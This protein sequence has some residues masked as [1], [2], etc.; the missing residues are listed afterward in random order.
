[1]YPADGAVETNPVEFRAEIGINS[2]KQYKSHY[3]DRVLCVELTEGS[4]WNKC[5]PM[6]NPSIIFDKLPIGNYTARAFITDVNGGV[7]WYHQTSETGF[8]VVTEEELAAYKASVQEMARGGGKLQRD[9][10]L[11]EWASQERQ[12]WETRAVAANGES[13]GRVLVNNLT[14]NGDEV[15]LLIGVKAAVVE[16]FAFRRAVRETWASE[17][18]LPNDVRVLFV[19]CVPKFDEV[20]SKA[21]QEAIKNAIELEKRMYGDLLTDELDCD[22]SYD[23]LPNKVKQFLRFAA[24]A[25]PRTPFVMIADDDIY[26]RADRL[27]GDLREIDRPRR[28]YIGQVWDNL[29]GR[30]QEPVRD[31]TERY[32]IPEDTY[33]LRNYP[34]FAFGPHYLL[35]MDCV[36]FIAKNYKR[37]RGLGP[38]DDVS[39]AL[40]LLARQVHVEHTSAFSSLGIGREYMFDILNAMEPV[41]ALGICAGSSRLPDT[42]H[43]T[44]R[45]SDWYN[46]DAVT[47]F[48]SY[49]FVIAFENSG[50]PGY[51][52]EK[53]VNP[54]L[55]GSIPIY[56]GNSTT[57][58]ELFNPNSFIDCGVFEK[59]RDCA[60]YVV[61][62]HRSPELY[63]QMR[64]EPPIRNVAAF[65]EAFSW[66][67]SVPSKAMA[68]KV[69]KLMQ[70]TN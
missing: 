62:V 10:G 65:N 69:A 2:M 13:P 58:S 67:P 32:Y 53:M 66:H 14:G 26:L 52:T 36:R 9:L 20:E 51:V 68:D 19:G 25:F 7:F 29:L 22:D 5:T 6:L 45:Y 3:G 23:D 64:R 50:V 30:S 48:Q 31:L 63:A 44:S 55:A 34:P 49:K 41:D 37:F 18:A 56:L 33:P 39:V 35:S 47:T 21:E 40:W 4:K 1:M 15:L 24:E 70:T 60:K 28:L 16:N 46:D 8:S 42:T 59:L 38:I 27:A 54:F 17:N 11:L 57:V 61:K 43:A 12:H